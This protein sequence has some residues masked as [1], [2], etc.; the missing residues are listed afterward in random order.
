MLLGP[1]FGIVAGVVLIR[2]SSASVPVVVRR[3]RGVVP[4]RRSSASDCCWKIVVEVELV[5]VVRSG[6]MLSMSR[7]CWW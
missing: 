3:S 5:V 1:K 7:C 6:S 2:R 4:I